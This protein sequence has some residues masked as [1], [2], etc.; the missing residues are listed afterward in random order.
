MFRFMAGVVFAR[1]SQD[2]AYYVPLGLAA[3]ICG[4]CEALLSFW[5]EICPRVHR[6]GRPI[7]HEEKYSTPYNRYWPGA[8]GGREGAFT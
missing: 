2:P 8:K 3:V 6:P 4:C 7:Y 5:K 1:H